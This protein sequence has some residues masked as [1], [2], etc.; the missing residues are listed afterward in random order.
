MRTVTARSHSF[1][2]R[3]FIFK[4]P[5]S[6]AQPTLFPCVAYALGQFC[7]PYSVPVTTLRHKGGAK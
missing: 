4:A 7:L 6:L 2:A 3:A 5:P 1:P